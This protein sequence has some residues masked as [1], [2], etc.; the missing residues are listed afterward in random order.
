MNTLA[1]PTRRPPT[2]GRYGVRESN[3]AA[4]ERAMRARQTEWLDA[5]N[6]GAPPEEVKRLA[7][8]FVEAKR[9]CQ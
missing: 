1:T 8:L 3:E 7:S 5:M 2:L 9:A 6:R 4:R